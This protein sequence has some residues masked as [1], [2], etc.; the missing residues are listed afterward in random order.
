MG[1]DDEGPAGEEFRFDPAL[2]IRQHPVRGVLQAFPARRAHIVAAPPDFHLA[3][4]VLADG[5]GLVHPLEVAVQPL[6]ERLVLLDRDVGLT[7]HRQDDVQG[8]DRPLEHGGV[9]AIES[10][11]DQLLAGHPGFLLPF[12]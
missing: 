9:R 2:V 4:A 7:D 1:S 10:E 5:F 8:V 3:L 11:P 6:V 12:P